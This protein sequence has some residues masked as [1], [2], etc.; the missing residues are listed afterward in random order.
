MPVERARR[1]QTLGAFGK[2][3]NRVASASY[4]GNGM[5]SSPI[6]QASRPRRLYSPQWM[7]RP[8]FACRH[9]AIRRSWSGGGGPFCLAS[10]VAEDSLPA[11]AA[12]AISNLRQ[13][14]RLGFILVADS[15]HCLKHA[16]L[17]GVLITSQVL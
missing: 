6:A 13:L 10:V 4:S 2:G 14:R 9:H 17:L 5:S 12:L 1:A 7:N 15:W 16:A 8:N 11:R 3:R